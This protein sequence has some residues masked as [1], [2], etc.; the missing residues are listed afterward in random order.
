LTERRKGNTAYQQ[1]DFAEA[2]ERYDRARAVVD[3]VTGMSAAD[4]AR[5]IVW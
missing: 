1:R 4:Q 2:L 3:F 5:V